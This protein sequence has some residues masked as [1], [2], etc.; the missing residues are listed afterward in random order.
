MILAKTSAR[1][2]PICVVLLP[3]GDLTVTVLSSADTEYDPLT[4][5]SALISVQLAIV[6]PQPVFRAVITTGAICLVKLAL[7]QK[8]RNSNSFQE[9]Y[10]SGA[11]WQTDF[12]FLNDT[13]NAHAR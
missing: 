10:G 9:F 2:P 13:Y 6:P 4:V 12:I 7:R 1:K 3:Y 5:I 11:V 8:T